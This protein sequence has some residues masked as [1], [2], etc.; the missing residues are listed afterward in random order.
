MTCT[1]RTF[2]KDALSCSLVAAL[3][4][5]AFTLLSRSEARAAVANA[6]VRWGFL[7]DTTKCIGDA[8]LG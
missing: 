3:P 2:M 4:A 7:V 8:H 6:N 5:S 1:R